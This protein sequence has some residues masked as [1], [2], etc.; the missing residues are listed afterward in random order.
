MTYVAGLLLYTSSALP[1]TIFIA[2]SNFSSFLSA[3]YQL[4]VGSYSILANAGDVNIRSIIAN[5][6]SQQFLPGEQSSCSVVYV[7]CNVDHMIL[8]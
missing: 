6:T 5:Q 3:D 7:V 2:P 8:S 1:N 4:A